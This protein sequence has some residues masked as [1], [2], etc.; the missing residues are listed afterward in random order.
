MFGED[1]D[2]IVKAMSKEERL[3]LE[4]KITNRSEEEMTLAALR[5]KKMIPNYHPAV[6]SSSMTVILD[7]FLQSRR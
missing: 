5:L 1:S 6:T 2:N 3:Q 4:E 7:K